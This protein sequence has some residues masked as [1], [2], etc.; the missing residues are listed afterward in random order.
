MKMGQVVYWKN[1]HQSSEVV[2]SGQV[3][4]FDDENAIVAGGFLAS[5]MQL[6]ARSRLKDTKEEAWSSPAG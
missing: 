1:R 4:N 5:T 3:I 6:I 2:H